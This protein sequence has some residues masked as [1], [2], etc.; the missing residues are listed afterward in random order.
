MNEV[1]CMESIVKRMTVILLWWRR[2]GTSSKITLGSTAEYFKLNSA[3]KS[4]TWM[5]A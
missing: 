5:F 3:S 4:I 1:K 2:K